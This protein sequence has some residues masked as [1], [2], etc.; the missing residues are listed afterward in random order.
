MIE[1]IVR[2]FLEERL[3]TDVF[4]EM[5]NNKTTFVVLEKTGSYEENCISTSTIAAQS[6]GSSLY[7]TA[8]LNKRVIEAMKD[9]IELDEISSCELNSDYNFTDTETKKYRYQAVFD[10]THY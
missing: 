5:P 1:E 7:K 2:C 3:Q 4:L 10:I 8:Q 6:Y 9:L